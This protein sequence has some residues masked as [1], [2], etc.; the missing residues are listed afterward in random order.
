[1][2]RDRGC[3]RHARPG[4]ALRQPRRRAAIESPAR[5][6]RSGG[7][8]IVLPARACSRRRIAQVRRVDPDRQEALPASAAAQRAF[9]S[10][11]DRC[12]DTVEPRA[13]ALDLGRQ[14]IE[15]A[16][17]H[18]PH[19]HRA[20]RTRAGG[21]ARQPFARFR[22][23]RR[24][25]RCHRLPAR[26]RNAARGYP[27][28]PAAHARSG[29]RAVAAGPAARR[30]KGPRRYP[31]RA[32]RGPVLCAIAA[33]RGRGHRLAHGVGRCLRA[34]RRLCRGPAA[35]ACTG[36]RRRPAAPA[37]RRQFRPPRLFQ[38]FWTTPARSATRAVR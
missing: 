13:S 5:R 9:G 10:P 35:A 23:D 26:Q 33:Q 3:C 27:A 31:G 29:T 12:A 22:C 17:R 11:R 36:A 2:D 24:Q 30:T 38:G 25:A 1:M 21:Q 18:R 32:C 28:R 15:P 8:R 7:I 19:R 6:R 37:P 20:R 16:R 14:I 4:S 34:P